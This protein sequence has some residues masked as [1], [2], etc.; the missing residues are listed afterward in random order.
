MKL[1]QLIRSGALGLGILL[2]AVLGAQAQYQVSTNANNTLTITN[3]TGPGGVVNVPGTIYSLTVSAIGGSTF[4]NNTN[5][6]SVTLPNSITNLGNYVFSNCPGLTNAVFGSGISSIGIDLF[7]GCTGLTQVTFSGNL[8]SIGDSAFDSCFGLTNFTIPNSVAHLG[9]YAFY[10]CTNLASVSFGRGVTNIGNDAFYNC[11][12]L[13][14]VTIPTNVADIGFNA[15]AECPGLTSVF[16][17]S[18]APVADPTAFQASTN[19]IAYYLP[20]TTGWPAFSTNTAVPAVLW[21]PQPQTHDGHFGVRTNRFGF[22]IT[23]STNVP[24]VV[25]VSTNLVGGA[26]TPVFTGSVTNGS[27]YFADPQ[28]TNH[29][30]AFY[31]IRSP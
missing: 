5:L 2:G 26:W 1:K 25:V 14:H 4:A 27:I 3:Y 8:T 12:S 15:F 31:R 9:N 24:V 10:S 19:T 30:R 21:N 17:A 7:G 22:T 18:N 13:A 23:A 29:P 6:A 11:F 20:G 28:W 16:F